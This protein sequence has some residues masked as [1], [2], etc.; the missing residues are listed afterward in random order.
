MNKYYLINPFIWIAGLKSLLLGL[1]G[2]ILIS[3][4]SFLTGTHMAG[5]SNI[6]FAK[7]AVYSIYLMEHL[8]GW[9]V[10]AL[11]L[12][13]SG[14]IFAKTRIRPIDI[15]GTSLL[16]RFPLILAPILR[17]IPGFDSFL[18]GS[19]QMYLIAG[20]FVLSVTWT[21]VLLLNGYKVSTNLKDERLW[22][23]F[24]S[25]LILSEIA[26]RILIHILTF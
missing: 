3:V 9:I 7:D 18:F 16:A 19:W 25:G 14:C 8:I 4:T 15:L 26:T 6:D 2:L 22:T 20:L 23:S 17:F 12:Y 5:L 21:I 10:L 13:L 1:T 11:F 24:I